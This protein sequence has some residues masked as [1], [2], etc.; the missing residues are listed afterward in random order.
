MDPMMFPDQSPAPMPTREMC[1]TAAALALPD[2]GE[3]MIEPEP[4][5][6]VNFNV[7]GTVSRVENGHAYITVAKVNGE[8]LAE[9]APAA[10]PLDAERAELSQLSQGY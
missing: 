2:E 4:G 10:D 3:Q 8:D 1:I 6:T 7:E 5:S 9:P